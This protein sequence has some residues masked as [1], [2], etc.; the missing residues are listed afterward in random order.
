MLYLE[1]IDGFR[2]KVWSTKR[3][4]L[5]LPFSSLLSAKCFKSGDYWTFDVRELDKLK[6]NLDLINEE[7]VIDDEASEEYIKYVESQKHLED[8]KNS[9]NQ[10][11][12]EYITEPF[13][14]QRIGVHYLSNRDRVGLFDE[15]GLGKTKQVLDALSVWRNCG[16]VKGG[17]VVICPNTAKFSWVEEVDKHSK[18]Y[19]YE[20]GNGTKRCRNDIEFIKK[21]PKD[22][23]IVH[24]DCLRYVVDELETL[25]PAFLF[26]DEFHFFKNVGTTRTSG[27]LRAQAL[28]HL[29]EKW[30][31][32]NQNLKVIVMTGTPVAERPEEAYAVLQILMPGFIASHSRFMNRYCKYDFKYYM[33]QKKGTNRRYRQK[34]REVVGYK[35][36]K[37]LKEL[38]ESVG[39]RRLKSEVEGFPE[40]IDIKKFVELEK[41]HLKAYDKIK[42]ATKQEIVK[43]KQSGKS[44]NVKNKFIRL[45]QVVNNPAVLDG[46]NVSCKYELLD[47]LLEE[48]MSS[49][50][51]KVVL[52]TIFTKA[53]ELLYGRYNKKYGV[54]CIFGDVQ[55]EDRGG[56]I[57][58]FN[59]K[60]RPRILLCNPAAGGTALNLQRAQ[61]AIYVDAM[62]A[63]TQRLQS[64]DR[65]HRR[66]SKGT[67]RVITIIAKDT[68]DEGLVELLKMKRNM[69][70]ALLTSDDLLIEQ[71][72]EYLLKFLE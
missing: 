7:T 27:S 71:N 46:E 57:K 45:M 44:F 38:L 59:E 60:K 51:E 22:L 65:I 13:N 53:I 12:Y 31:K 70:D 11:E 23:F 72:R 21:N 33:V 68:V 6:K 37:E 62:F 50:E 54:E 48:I 34:V 63:L 1:Y 25:S 55:I 39:I 40:K 17:G 5:A 28:F 19:H 2:I 20:I 30:K 58:R 69:K 67:V 32:K 52:W 36:L 26:V 18:F 64:E 9:S 49:D 56:I 61:T 16:S 3:M 8:I 41:E 4:S 42:T 47:E 43:L 66:S 24:M 14:E 15:M 10:F 35:N 29:V